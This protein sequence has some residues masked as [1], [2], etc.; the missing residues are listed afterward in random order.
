MNYRVLWVLVARTTPTPSCRSMANKGARVRIPVRQAVMWG[1]SG[2][3]ALSPRAWW[4]MTKQ[5]YTFLYVP[6]P[7]QITLSV[8]S[9]H[10]SSKAL[11][12]NIQ[13][14]PSRV[15]GWTGLSNILLSPRSS[16]MTIFKSSTSPLF[17]PCFKN[18]EINFHLFQT[19]TDFISKLFHQFQ[20]QLG[21]KSK[22]WSLSS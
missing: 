5:S 13:G 14:T 9:T 8:R 10:H 1:L 15:L 3:D 18:Q 11:R 2:L 17:P 7:C 6:I 19:L 4:V 12:S 22:S 20:T 16:L 21:D